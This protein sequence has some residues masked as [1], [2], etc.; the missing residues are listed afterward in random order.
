V[1]LTECEIRSVLFGP[2]GRVEEWNLTINMRAMT[3]NNKE[4]PVSYLTR[5]RLSGRRAWD[6]P[7]P[8]RA[9]K[10]SLP[11]PWMVL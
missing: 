11:S 6:G 1:N 8:G 5:F 10:K 7:G 9:F 4:S 2:H 3:V